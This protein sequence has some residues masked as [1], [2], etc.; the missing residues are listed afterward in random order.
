M[1][2]TDLKIA[3]FESLLEKDPGACPCAFFTGGM[4]A[5][6]NVCGRCDVT[7]KQDKEIEQ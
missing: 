6:C 7:I 4:W 2:E 1:S 3:E 5:D